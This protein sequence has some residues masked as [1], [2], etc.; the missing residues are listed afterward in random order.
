MLMANYSNK[1]DETGCI[2]ALEACGCSDAEARRAVG[3]VLGFPLADWMGQ[4]DSRSEIRGGT[5]P[6]RI[7]S[8]GTLRVF[9]SPIAF[10]YDAVRS[11][12]SWDGQL[13]R[14]A[15]TAGQIRFSGDGANRRFAGS[16][17]SEGQ[18]R[19]AG[20]SGALAR[21][22]HLW[23]SALNGPGNTGRSL[24]RGPSQPTEAWKTVI[25]GQMRGGPAV[26]A[27]GLVYVGGDNS[28]LYCL[29][30]DGSIL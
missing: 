9:E 20:Y 8:D 11:Q 24:F 17:T 7:A 12:L 30:P 2:A 23:P 22:V 6:L 28:R 25:G 21:A 16:G 14:G 18:S 27:A 4:Y 15:R 5:F 10:S 3:E 26:D 1:L 29:Q 13:I 19:P